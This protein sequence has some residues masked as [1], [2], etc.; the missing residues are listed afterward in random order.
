MKKWKPNIEGKMG[1]G[2]G[3]FLSSNVRSSVRIHL[4][5]GEKTKNNKK[6]QAEAQIKILEA[7]R[8]VASS[9]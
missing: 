7:K 9:F 4:P 1:H 3:T 5:L 2:S 8:A 6:R